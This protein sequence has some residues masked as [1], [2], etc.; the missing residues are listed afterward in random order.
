M[1]RR[2]GFTLIELLVVIAIIAL[3]MSILM[4][5]LGKAKAAAVDAVD[6]NNLHQFGLFWQMFTND[7][8]GFFPKRGSG[9][10][11]GQVTMGAWPYVLYSYMPSFD[12]KTWLCPGAKKPHRDGGVYPFAAW[13]RD[14]EVDGVDV[15]IHGSY[16]ANFWVAKE[17]EAKFFKTIRIKGAYQVPIMACG[18]WK[19]TEPEPYDEPWQTMGEIVVEGWEGGTNE[20]KRVC[21]FRHGR[22]VNAVFV[23]NSTRRIGLKMLWATKWHAKWYDPPVDYPE[24]PPWMRD[25]PDPP[26]IPGS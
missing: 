16:S 2:F 20:M 22:F 10:V 25:F 5:T 19:D 14:G 7:N 23:D 17:P 13:S 24:W 11:W 8:D 21:H 3:L 1:R 9:D 12:K 6:K 26:P 18:N 4:P 15:T